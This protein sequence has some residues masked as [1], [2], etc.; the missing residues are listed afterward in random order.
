MHEQY[1][2]GP[3]YELIVNVNLTLGSQCRKTKLRSLCLGARVSFYT[4]PKLQ[5][6][7]RVNKYTHITIKNPKTGRQVK[8]SLKNKITFLHCMAVNKK[9][10]EKLTFH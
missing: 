7:T 4:L 3:F 9:Q 10:K 1:H 8:R 5:L 2:H 6:S